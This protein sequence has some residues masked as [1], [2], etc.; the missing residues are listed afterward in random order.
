MS[1]A[2]KIVPAIWR[3][4]VGFATPIPTFPL[5]RT[6]NSWPEVELETENIVEVEIEDVPTIANVETGPD[7]PIPTFPAAVTLNIEVPVEEAKSIKA[8]EPAAPCTLKRAMG[9]EVP[10]PTALF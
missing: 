5:A 7:V 9:V 10:T 2:G 6:V 1:L 8:F 4:D 3:A